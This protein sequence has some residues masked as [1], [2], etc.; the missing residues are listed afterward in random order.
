MN[1]YWTI[2]LF[3]ALPATFAAAEG[4][5]VVEGQDD[6]LALRVDL[7]KAFPLF[8]WIAGVLTGGLAVH[9]WWGGIICFAPVH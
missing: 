9:F 2:W 3:V 8:P 5:R 4:Y 6:A 1:I 7:S